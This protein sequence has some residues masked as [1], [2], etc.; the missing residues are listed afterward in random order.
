VVERSLAW[1]VGCRRLQVRYEQRADILLGFVHLACALICLKPLN[2]AKVRT[3]RALR[4]AGD[5]A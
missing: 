3:P 5:A 2:Q 1:L 4:L